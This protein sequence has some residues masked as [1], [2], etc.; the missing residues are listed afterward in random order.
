MS[1]PVQILLLLALFPMVGSAREETLE[2]R[3]QRITRKYMRER[4]NVAQSDLLVPS[5]VIEDERITESEGF[6][7][8]AVDFKRQES[9]SM[10]PPPPPEARARPRRTNRNWLLDDVDPEG[11]DESDPYADPY[12]DSYSDPY[13]DAY[14]DP[15]ADASDTGGKDN[16]WSLW[17]E[18]KEESAT[19]KSSDDDR[20]RHDQKDSS[21]RVD[22]WGNSEFSGEEQGVRSGFSS[23]GAGLFGGNNDP[24]G[25]SPNSGAL[26]TPVSFKAET[27]GTERSRWGNEGNNTPYKSPY[28]QQ[29]NQQRE[30]TRS[31]SSS[32]QKQEYS[33]PNSYQ[34][35][36]SKNAEFDP[37][38]MD[39]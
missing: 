1:K 28:Q 38:K 34:Q 19:E 35:W 31:W 16:Y 36:K 2:E 14:T 25:S 24:Y 12:A 20:Y 29:K 9:G 7:D 32:Q 17:G 13:E 30:Q 8:L 21:G 37:S 11:G 3:K 10:P 26:Y 5:E 39:R 27:R 6:N 4:T 15:Y 18:D 33:K 23:K 22:I